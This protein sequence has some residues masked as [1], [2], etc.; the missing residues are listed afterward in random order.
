MPNAF[1]REEIRTSLCGSQEAR[2]KVHEC[3]HEKQKDFNEVVPKQEMEEKIEMYKTCIDSVT[4]E[5]IILSEVIFCNSYYISNLLSNLT[6]YQYI[7]E[8]LFN[9]E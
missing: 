1:T 2:V 7:Y 9:D 3:M 8:Q 4:K 6:I 5:P